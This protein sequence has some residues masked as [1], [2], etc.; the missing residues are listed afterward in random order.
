MNERQQIQVKT[1]MRLDGYQAKIEYD[2]ESSPFR[3]EILG[4]NGSADFYSLNPSK[5]RAQFSQSLQ[6]F[7]EVCQ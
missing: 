5:L 2:A 6:V 3:R 4:L 7:L 1:P